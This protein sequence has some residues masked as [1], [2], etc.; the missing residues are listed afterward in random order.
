VR[1]LEFIL[2]DAKEKKKDCV[3]TL[4]NIQSNHARATAVSIF[5]L[6]MCTYLPP[7]QAHV[8]QPLR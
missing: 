4:G 5:L 3:V 8:A 7:A 6:F 2:A 1:K